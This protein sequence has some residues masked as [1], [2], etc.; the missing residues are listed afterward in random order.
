[1]TGYMNEWLAEGAMGLPLHCVNQGKGATSLLLLLLAL[2]REYHYPYS[3]VSV[4]G[5]SC[6]SLLLCVLLLLLFQRF[7]LLCIGGHLDRL[8]PASFWASGRALGVRGCIAHTNL[9]EVAVRSLL[10]ES[11]V[12]ACKLGLKRAWD[13]DVC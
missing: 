3:P 1:M 5:L 13:P 6:V 11:P 12:V 4:F 9:P 2:D 10:R 8:G 7:Q